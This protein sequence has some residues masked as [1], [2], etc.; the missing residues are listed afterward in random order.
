MQTTLTPTLLDFL[1]RQGYKYFLS[2]TMVADTIGGFSIQIMLTPVVNRPD[3]R[4]LPEG[5]DTYFQINQEPR[6]M[7]QGIDDTKVI[8]RLSED[9]RKLFEKLSLKAG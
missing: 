9:D 7:A 4:S 5:F 8:V 2:K 1:A 6:Q 3:I